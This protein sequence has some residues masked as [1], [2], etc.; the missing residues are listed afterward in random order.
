MRA[1]RFQWINDFNVV[2]KDEWKKKYVPERM[3]Y[4]RRVQG[5]SSVVQTLLTVVIRPKV[6]GNSG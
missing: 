6:C 1:W 2:I 4:G 5:V 3:E